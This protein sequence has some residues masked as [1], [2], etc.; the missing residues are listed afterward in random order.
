MLEILTLLLAFTFTLLLV[1]IR[2]EPVVDG[3]VS[4]RSAE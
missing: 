3:A 4:V 2:H 1:F